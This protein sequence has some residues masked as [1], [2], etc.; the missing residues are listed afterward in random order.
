MIWVVMLIAVLPGW[1]RS[2]EGRNGE[3]VVAWFKKEIKA[4]YPSGNLTAG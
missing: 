4:R 2:F 1:G 3:R